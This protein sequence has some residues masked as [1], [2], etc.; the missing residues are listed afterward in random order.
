MKLNTIIYNV[1]TNKPVSI[2]LDD[3]VKGRALFQ[4][5][6]GGGKSYLL[7]K[8]L[9]ESNGKIQQIIIDPE[10]EFSTLREK[11]DYLLVGKDNADIQIDINHAELLAKRLMET[12]A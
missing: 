3:I 12:G 8:F 10:G 6:S 11:Y 4:A 7:R 5:N 1:E 9:E 2:D